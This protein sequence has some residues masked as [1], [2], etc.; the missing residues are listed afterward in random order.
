MSAH[1]VNCTTQLK[2]SLLGPVEALNR[3]LRLPSFLAGFALVKH[4]QKCYIY[5][6]FVHL[7]SVNFSLLNAVCISFSKI[8]GT[9][10]NWKQKFPHPYS[11]LSWRQPELLMCFL[12][13]QFSYFVRLRPPF[14]M[15]SRV[16]TWF[17]L[18]DSYILDCSFSGI[19]RD[20]RKHPW[21]SQQ[22]CL[23]EK[24]QIRLINAEK[25]Q[26]SPEKRKQIQEKWAMASER[27]QILNLVSWMTFN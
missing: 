14:P 9:K 5:V 3:L 2:L 22:L 20:P 19:I 21:H 16:S 12:K 1:L 18:A 24:C 17:P 7:E 10:N 11:V 8:Y 4:L 6:K 13:I 27:P 26:V 23:C 25:K 15:S